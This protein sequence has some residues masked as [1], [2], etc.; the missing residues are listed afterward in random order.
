MRAAIC[1]ALTAAGFKAMMGA[2]PGLQAVKREN[3]CNRCR[4]GRGVQLEISAGL[5]RKLLTG[6]NNH[7]EGRP[8][9]F[10]ALFVSAIRQALALG[11][12]RRPHAPH[13]RASEKNNPTS[14]LSFGP[15]PALHPPAHI[16]ICADG[17]A[18]VTNQ[19]PAQ[20]CGIIYSRDPERT[21]HH[22]R[23]K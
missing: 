3:L 7:Q 11:A 5:R 21:P 23:K 15:S 18:L 14:C 9:P 22:R 10:F 13:V 17:C 4:S 20:S 16:S 2:R 1:T 19:N 8:T 6:L 12:W